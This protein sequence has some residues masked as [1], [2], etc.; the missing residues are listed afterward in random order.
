MSDSYE[1]G[2]WLTNPQTGVINSMGS[3]QTQER[4]REFV[5]ILGDHGWVVVRRHVGP[6]EVVENLDREQQ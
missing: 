2:A 3:V 5:E 1:W 6:W 4:A